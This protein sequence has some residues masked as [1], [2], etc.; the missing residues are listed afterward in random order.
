[1][2]RAEEADA[3]EGRLDLPLFLEYREL[4]VGLAVTGRVL[5]CSCL[6]AALAAVGLRYPPRDRGRAELRD[7]GR[8]DEK[9]TGS[10]IPPVAMVYL[11]TMDR[12]LS[13]GSVHAMLFVK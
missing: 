1:M 9:G 13:R 3:V 6:F 12:K 10:P 5:C 11:H 7:L 2:R 8:S 4:D